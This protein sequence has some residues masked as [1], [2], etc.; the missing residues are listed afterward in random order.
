MSA[1]EI[2]KYSDVA[3]WIIDNVIYTPFKAKK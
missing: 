3:L 2:D 1:E